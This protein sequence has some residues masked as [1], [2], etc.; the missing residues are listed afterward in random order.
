MADPN[1]LSAAL[2]AADDADLVKEAAPE[3]LAACEKALSDR[4]STGEDATNY[5]ISGAA[6][7]QIRAAVAW[8]K[9]G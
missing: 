5:I 7:R 9:E 4:P 6:M 2:Q 1:D 3:L 8:A